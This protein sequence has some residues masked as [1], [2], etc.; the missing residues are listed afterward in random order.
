[1]RNQ[2]ATSGRWLLE[3][4][5]DSRDPDRLIWESADSV[6]ETR[7]AIESVLGGVTWTPEDAE[8]LGGDDTEPAYGALVREEFDGNIVKGLS[9]LRHDR[10]SFR[11]DNGTLTIVRER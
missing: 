1:M 6:E 11:C 7:A 10:I 9:D 8:E 5:D 3:W 4:K 2:E